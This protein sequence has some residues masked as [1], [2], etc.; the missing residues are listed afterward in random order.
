MLIDAAVLAG[1]RSSRLG[2]A[3]KASLQVNGHSLLE[4]AVAAASRVSRTC[5]VVGP[6]DPGLLSATVLITRED[7]PFSGPAAALAAGVRQLSAR[8]T[9]K[10]TSDAILVLAC[11]MP[12]IAAQIPLLATALAAAPADAD[13][14]ISVDVFGQRQP[15][16]CLY[17]TSALVDAISRFADSD[18]IG[19]SMR[20]LIEPLTLI[21]VAAVLGATDDVDT[22]EDAA[23]LGA[24][25]SATEMKED[26]E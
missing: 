1:G 19:L 7:P 23:R 11:D 20:E 21:P 4:H 2:S 5:V 3:A 15:L 18:L 24:T 13:G 10:S 22:W 14:A 6:I 16:A 12:G 25:D 9:S 17:R 8:R 26:A